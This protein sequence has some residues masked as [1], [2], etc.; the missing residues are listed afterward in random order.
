MGKNDTPTMTMNNKEY[1]IAGL[2][3]Q[4]QVLLSHVTDLDRKIKSVGFNLDQLRIGR[5][6]FVNML[7]ASLEAPAEEEAA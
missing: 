1:D 3:D 4:Q 7:S 2:S 5:E 6:A